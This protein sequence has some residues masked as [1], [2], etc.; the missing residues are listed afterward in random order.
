MGGVVNHMSQ[1]T[2]FSYGLYSWLVK[3]KFYLI[4]VD[5][6]TNLS[7]FTQTDWRTVI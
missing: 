6:R 1:C 3:I 4:D 5:L 2:S 7:D